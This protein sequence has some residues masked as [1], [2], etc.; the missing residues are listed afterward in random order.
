MWA[1]PWERPGWGEG[2][3]EG[4]TGRR[5]LFGVIF[6]TFFSG[7]LRVMPL[8]LEKGIDLPRAVGLYG[9]AAVALP[10]ADTLVPPAI[11]SR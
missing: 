10:L 7:S 4:R 1:M 6:R 8:P 3:V 5:C 2:G 11:L 9:D